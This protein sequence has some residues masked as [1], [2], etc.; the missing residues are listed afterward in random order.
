MS[1]YLEFLALI[2]F[3]V[4]WGGYT[5]Y[6]RNRANSRSC[7]SN[8]LDLY[9][10]DWM[11]VMLKRENRISDASVVGNLERNGA[12]FASSCLLILAGIITALGYTSEAME[13]FAT[14]PFSAVPSR[15]IWE[16][17]LVVLL[18]VFI[19]AFFKFTWSMRMYNFVAVM[20][21]SAPLPD[22]SK[23]SPAAREAFARSAGNICNLA[24][25][26]FNLGLRSYY[27]ALAVVAWFIHP[28]A[29]MAAS[30]LVVY[31]LYR[32]EFHSDALSALRD[33]KVF[34][35]A[36]PARADADVKSKN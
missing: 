25:D 28:V 16:L 21:G 6:S 3:F 31:V 17:R 30:T 8:T 33:G 23:T 5:W 36:I 1:Y 27:Y 26:A 34:E 11:R 14:M 10:E 12:F 19:Y 18:V 32:R 24:G 9:R 29:F 2:W 20:I 22:D 15:E 13:I 35:E 7:L 4:C